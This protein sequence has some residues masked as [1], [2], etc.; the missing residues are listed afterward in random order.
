MYVS[1]DGFF[2][3]PSLTFS[4]SS[5]TGDMLST[6]KYVYVFMYINRTNGYVKY[7]LNQCDKFMA[8]FIK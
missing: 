4:T 5:W 6:Y 2:P 1:G 7:V 3:S 8:L